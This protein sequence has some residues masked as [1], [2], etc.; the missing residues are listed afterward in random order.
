M[1]DTV[2]AA[3]VAAVGAV[4][5][6]L[7]A[8]SDRRGESRYEAL[9]KQL[10]EVDGRVTALDAAVRFGQQEVTQRIDRLYDVL[11]RARGEP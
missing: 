5:V 9:A 4:L 8:R 3:L 11:V 6:A 1:S 2:V 10:A 7:I